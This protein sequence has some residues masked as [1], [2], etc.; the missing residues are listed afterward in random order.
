LPGCGLAGFR[1]VWALGSAGAIATFPLLA[2]IEAITM[3]GE[4]GD[5]GANDRAA[6]ACAERWLDAGRDAFVVEPQIGGDLNDV[7]R[8]LMP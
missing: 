2:G 3:L 8:E 4:A 6:Q 1:P 7:W 5:G